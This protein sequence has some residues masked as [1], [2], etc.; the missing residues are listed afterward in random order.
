MDS[1]VE[2]NKERKGKKPESSRK[3]KRVGP[4]KF[5]LCSITLKFYIGQNSELYL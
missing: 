2:V 1:K 3:T 4:S 5:F